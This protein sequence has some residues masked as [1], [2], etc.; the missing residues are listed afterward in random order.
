MR[1]TTRLR[2]LVAGPGIAMI[3]GAHDALAAR[4]IE[5]AGFPA[6]YMTGAGT[7]AALLG[8]PDVGL[9]TMTEMVMN[10]RYIARAVSIPLVCDADTGY[11]NAVNVMRTV[12]EYEAAGAAGIHLED[13]VFPKKC[14]HM[15]GKALIP[16]E[17]MA[18]KI[19]AA[20]EARQDPD[21][22]I[23]A[24]TDSRAVEGVE[25]AIRRARLYAE[26]G[27]DVI[28]PEA[29]QSRDELARFAAEIRAP[30][31]AN[32][33]EFGKTP[34]VPAAE[35]ERMGYR[36]VIYPASALRV[37]HRAM[38]ELFAQIK[39]AGSQE[40]CLDRMAHRQE[41]YELVGLPA[42]HVAERR[43]LGP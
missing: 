6:C 24:R 15:D 8:M 19:R 25:A 7:V 22:V 31:L 10:A 14:G 30:L 17:E 1:A 39:R 20:C 5:Q 4:L 41:L 18:G 29:P 38:E 26:A 16:A 27:A 42:V 12:R 9:I 28:F 11:G 34:L 35:L 36:L 2:T 21:F 23:I 40:A 32:M 13:Q 43:F 3:P 33:T 37:A